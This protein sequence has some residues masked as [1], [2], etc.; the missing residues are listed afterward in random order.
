[1]QQFQTE[2][3]IFQAAFV[4]IGDFSLR[5][6]CR[7]ISRR[8]DNPDSDIEVFTLEIRKLLFSHI[9]VWIIGTIILVYLYL[10]MFLN[11]FTK[12]QHE[13]TFIQFALQHVNRL[14]HRV[15][16]Q[17]LKREFVQ[18]LL[19]FFK[20]FTDNELIRLIVTEQFNSSI[21]IILQVTET[22]HLAEAFL[23]VQHTVG[24]AKCL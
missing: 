1:M 5:D 12:S 8:I 9:E 16:P 19:H 15:F 23:L 13:V 21:H 18:F 3:Y 2:V 24:T 4:I 7:C 14:W 17:E 10:R 22:Y 11:D 20:R 6:H